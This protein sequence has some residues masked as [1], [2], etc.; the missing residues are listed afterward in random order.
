M[1]TS[2]SVAVEEGMW[3]SQVTSQFKDVFYR[4]TGV[5]VSNRVKDKFMDDGIAREGEFF[6]EPDKGILMISASDEE[7]V[8]VM[9]FRPFSG[10]D[11]SVLY[12]DVYTKGCESDL[13]IVMLASCSIA[14]AQLANSNIEDRAKALGGEFDCRPDEMFDSLHCRREHSSL[15][16]AVQEVLENITRAKVGD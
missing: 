16:D 8:G 5:D 6:L 13:E 14:V 2:L 7:V 1:S 4:L 9:I 15:E 12:A 10:Y 3:S 11:D